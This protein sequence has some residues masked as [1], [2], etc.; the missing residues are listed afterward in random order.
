VHQSHFRQPC[1]RN[2]SFCRKL[3]RKVLE[4]TREVLVLMYPDCFGVGKPNCSFMG[5]EAKA[6]EYSYYPE[7]RMEQDIDTD[8]VT[9][10]GA[11]TS[12]GFGAGTWSGSTPA[13]G[14]GTGIKA[15]AGG[16]STCSGVGT[17]TGTDAVVSKNGA[18]D[19]SD[20][21]EW[22][23]TGDSNIHVGTATGTDAVV[24]KKNRAGDDS[25]DEEWSIT[26]D[27]N[28]HAGGAGHTID[29]DDDSASDNEDNYDATV[30]PDNAATGTRPRKDRLAKLREAYYK[31]QQD[32]ANGHLPHTLSLGELESQ[33]QLNLYLVVADS[34]GIVK[35]G[36]STSD[37]QALYRRY[38]T[39]YGQVQIFAYPIHRPA[40]DYKGVIAAL[41]DANCQ[42]HGFPPLAGW[43]SVHIF[44]FLA[45]VIVSIILES[46]ALIQAN[47]LSTAKG[48]A[49]LERK[50]NGGKIDELEHKKEQ[51]KLVQD[52]DYWKIA[53]T[54][55]RTLAA[56]HTTSVSRRTLEQHFFEIFDAYRIPDSRELFR[57]CMDPRLAIHSKNYDVVNIYK[58]VM[59]ALAALSD[60]FA[61][62][63]NFMTFVRYVQFFK[64]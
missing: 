42:Q 38:K 28:M 31:L 16:G 57:T 41:S 55:A 48:M 64:H 2:G 22:S 25:D 17:A 32:I 59:W 12:S 8:A 1:G 30:R 37:I 60:N 27:S 26:G 11:G 45:I 14:A 3:R 15:A 63:T 49:A 9:A 50:L 51:K 58:D 35:A 61:E 13:T 10:T 24:S 52:A 43:Q 23:A 20:D 40:L 18:G 53:W 39:Y 4:E 29:D 34:L 54:Q 5:L 36:Y 6:G 19:D 47:I 56:Y 21:E 33:K 44:L 7:D 62:L 46:A